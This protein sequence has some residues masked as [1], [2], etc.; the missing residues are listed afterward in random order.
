[1]R[2]DFLLAPPFAESVEAH[3]GS[4][5]AGARFGKGGGHLSRTLMLEELTALLA[6]GKRL[7]FKELRVRAVEE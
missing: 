2:S 3:A 6:G 4:L 5:A 1:M 7:T